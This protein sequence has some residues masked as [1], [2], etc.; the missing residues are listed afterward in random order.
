MADVTL[1]DQPIITSLLDLDVYK[2]RMGQFVFHRYRD[3]PVRYKL[4]NR[5]QEFPL[6]QY[7]PLEHLREELA[8]ITSLTFS[9]E[10][11]LYLYSLPHMASDYVDSLTTAQLPPLR[12]EIDPENKEQFII[13]TE[14]DSWN[15][16]ILWETLVLS[17]VSELFSRYY[18]AKHLHLSK[19]IIQ[20][21]KRLRYKITR[22]NFYPELALVDFG[23]RRR[24]AKWWQRYV[25]RQ[26]TEGFSNNQFKGTSNVVLAKE[27]GIP[28][29]G[30]MAHEL[31]M[32][33]ACLEDTDVWIY[34]SQRK[35]LEEWY[36]E[37]GG[38]LS[39]ALSDTF[40]SDAFYNDFDRR[41]AKLYLGSRHDSGDPINYGER[42][43]NHYHRLGLHADSK[44]ITFSDG[45]TYDGI[46]RLHCYFKNRI[47][48][49]YGWGTT[50][51]NDLGVPTLSI[52]MKA[53]EACGRSTVKLSDNLNK[54]TGELKRIDR[55][56]QI[57]GYTNT[58]S[59]ECVV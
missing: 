18:V 25:V 42:T 44:A 48:Q 58:S 38:D 2:L 31:F 29:I 19:V 37:Y 28:T 41:I 35:I 17:V 8:H 57:F 49:W 24:F 20:G 4:H 39:I 27:F 36:S 40:G 15:R 7:I 5:T 56:K 47:K 33:I 9:S 22:L 54:A 45:L 12:I 50:E 34:Q 59:S 16:L 32:V 6:T 21:R 53:V 11:L 51:T 3:T 30:T 23:T 13:E 26:M 46:I 55:F 10:E 43:I 14:V 52:V 1:S